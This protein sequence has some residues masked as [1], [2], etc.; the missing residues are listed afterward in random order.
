MGKN[1]KKRLLEAAL[2][3]FSEKGFLGATTKEIA[4]QA[5]VAEVTLFRHFGSKEN[6]FAETINQYSFL[7]KLKEILPEIKTEPPDIALKKIAREFL[8]V[9][10]SK[11]NLIRIMYT[12]FY[13]YP[14]YIKKIHESIVESIIELISSYFNEL[15]ER[16]IFRRVNTQFAARAFLGMFFSYFYAKKIK[17][18]LNIRKNDLE[19][20][21]NCY[22]DLFIKGIELKPESEA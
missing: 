11:K 2:K 18:F 5:G 4:K 3:V 14:D 1:T 10:E 12:D 20:I 21:I 6:L 7:P 22:V 15:I 17:E 9:L 13:R 8:N 19:E 16:G